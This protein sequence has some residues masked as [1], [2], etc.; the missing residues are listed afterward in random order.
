MI[1]HVGLDDYFILT[2]LAVVIAM[3]IM[4][5]FHVSWGTG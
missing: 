1:R 4:N 5:V 3:S 2:A